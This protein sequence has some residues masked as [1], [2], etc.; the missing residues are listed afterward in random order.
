MHE[1]ALA[2]R[3]LAAVL[4]SAGTARVRAVR[5]WIA[6]SE[7]LSRESLAFHFAAHARGTL[8]EDARLELRL[9]HVPAR[10]RTCGLTWA[11]EHHVLLCPACGAPDG[12]L[13][14]PTGVGVDALEVDA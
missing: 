7:A 5:G 9:M 1:S 8:A 14:G 3:I 6:E 11:P 13:L 12:E 10:C 4:A 2:R